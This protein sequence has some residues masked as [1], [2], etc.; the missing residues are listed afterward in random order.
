MRRMSLRVWFCLLFAALFLAAVPARAA[1]T[2]PAGSEKDI[3]YNNDYHTYQ[4][5]NGTSWIPLNWNATYNPATTWNPSDMGAGLA[6]SNGNLTATQNST[7][8]TWYMVR[9]TKSYTVGTNHKVVFA[10][11]VSA[12]DNSNGWITGLAD[13]TASL[14]SDVGSTGKALGQQIGG[15]G[16]QG[17]GGVTVSNNC[18]GPALG[19]GGTLYYAVNFNTGAVWCSTDCTSWAGGAPDSGGAGGNATL[20]SATAFFIA[21]AG[22]DWNASDAATLN[23]NPNMAGCTGVSTFTGWN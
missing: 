21:W 23:T 15:A 22:R 9:S 3:M 12:Y 4:F 13:S 6:L 7:L 16:I 18:G 17:S 10:I 2:N 8:Y 14:T 19:V 20:T 11:T 1:C 5:C